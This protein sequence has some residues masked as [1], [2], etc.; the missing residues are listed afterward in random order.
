MNNES[1]VGEATP[2]EATACAAAFAATSA[3]PCGDTSC[4]CSMADMVAAMEGVYS[5]ARAAS[6]R[7]LGSPAS[8]PEA[9]SGAAGVQHASPTMGVAAASTSSC[10]VLEPAGSD[11]C[12]TRDAATATPASLC[13]CDIDPLALP[14]F[15]GKLAVSASRVYA[16]LASAGGVND[17][18]PPSYTPGSMS[19]CPRIAAALDAPL[20]TAIRVCCCSLRYGSRC[21]ACSATA[22]S[23]GSACAACA[24]PSDSMRSSGRTLTSSDVTELRARGCSREFSSVGASCVRAVP[25]GCLVGGTVG[26]LCAAA[27]SGSHNHESA[28]APRTRCTMAARSAA[29]VTNAVCCTM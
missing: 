24:E 18:S 3:E 19:R 9:S 8:E 6:A 2:E 16:A 29:T 7:A 25:R 4:S 27:S 26:A 15:I 1:A 17:S 11:P 22:W 23:S 14:V 12:A 5:V 13:A 10:H 21:P 28:A 20:A